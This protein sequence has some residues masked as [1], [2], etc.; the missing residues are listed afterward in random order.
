L[1]FLCLACGNKGTDRHFHLTGEVKSLDRTHHTASV[2]AAA[3]PG[4]ME[5]MTMEYPVKSADDF[6]RLRVG[7]HIDATVNVHSDNSY[8]L[9]DIHESEAKK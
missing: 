1:I 8:D 2:D 9:S 7:E 5:A 3:I 6:D 4:F